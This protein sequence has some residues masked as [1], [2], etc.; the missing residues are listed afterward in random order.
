M[1]AL[2]FGGTPGPSGDRGKMA[3]A[4][5]SP[6]RLALF[7]RSTPHAVPLVPVQLQSIELPATIEGK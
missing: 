1:H 3:M 6:A 5:A 2:M 7:L 4:V